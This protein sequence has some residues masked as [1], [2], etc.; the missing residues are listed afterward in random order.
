MPHTSHEQLIELTQVFNVPPDVLYQAWTEF[1][2]LQ[3]WW[4]PMGA[5]LVRLTNDL[6]DGGAVRYEFA[7]DNGSRH[8]IVEGTYRS[9]QPNN[10]LEYTWNWKMPEEPVHEGSWLL[11]I[12]FVEEN[13]KTRLRVLQEQFANEEAIQPHREGWDSALRELDRY[14]ERL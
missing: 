11:K 2:H 12:T 8:F 1:G 10:Y 4:R 5:R 14:L 9:V 3:A 7:D 13:G 6:R